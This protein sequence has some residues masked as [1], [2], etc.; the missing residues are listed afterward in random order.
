MAPPTPKAKKAAQ[1][2][3]PKAEKPV[4]V[5]Q[6]VEPAKAAPAAPAPVVVTAPA[7]EKSAA[8]AEAKKPAAPK[9][10]SSKSKTSEPQLKQTNLSESMILIDSLS[11]GGGL[12]QVKEPARSNS[13]QSSSESLQEIEDGKLS[14]GHRLSL[15]FRLAKNPILQLGWTAIK[16]KKKPVRREQ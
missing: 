6:P 14:L 15:H 9:S 1:P 11:G 4:Q 2:A 16:S 13:N 7:A 10:A 3:S 8:P 12:K 5:Q